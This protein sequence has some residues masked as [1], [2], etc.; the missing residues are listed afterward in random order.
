MYLVVVNE[1]QLF[2]HLLAVVVSGSHCDTGM[3]IFL[4]YHELVV[5]P[6]YIVVVSALDF[7]LHRSYFFLFQSLHFILITSFSL[8]F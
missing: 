7:P 5:S 8:R 3:H 4:P 1:R 2:V 6:L